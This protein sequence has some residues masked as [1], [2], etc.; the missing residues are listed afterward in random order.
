MMMPILPFRIA[1]KSQT[2][3]VSGLVDTGAAIN[4]LP[5]DIGVRLGFDW[6]A[7]KFF[8]PLAGMLAGVPAKAIA[9]EAFIGSYPVTNLSFAWANASSVPLLLGHM[10]FFREFDVCF[11]LL[12][13]EFT[14]APATP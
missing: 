5:Y 11:H 12:R 6:A 14:L 4:L 13:G 9:V 3:N 7:E 1:R 10:N 8:V 2:V